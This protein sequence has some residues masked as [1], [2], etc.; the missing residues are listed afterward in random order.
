MSITDKKTKARK[1][2][3]ADDNSVYKI[4]GWLIAALL[5][6]VIIKY[7]I[8]PIH[9]GNSGVL[10]QRFFHGTRLDRFY[11]EGVHIIFP[12]DK[13][14]IYNRR[15][16]TVKEKITALTSTG[17]P[18]EIE[19]AVYFRVSNDYLPHLH[20]NI[21]PD[22]I[23][24]IV[25]PMIISIIRRITGQLTAEDVFS[26]QNDFTNRLNLT[27]NITFTENF[28]ELQ[29]VYLVKISLPEAIIKAIEQKLVEKE[30]IARKIFAVQAERHEKLRR[31]I[32][33]K[34]IAIYNKTVS[35]S[36]SPDILTWQGIE[37]TRQLSQSNNTKTII[38][39]SGKE[40]LPIILNE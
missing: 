11:G 34:G 6:V 3:K 5:I 31:E 10:W 2:R 1:Q 21:G 23:N 27:A 22:Y 36:L 26:F 13:M 7:S 9:A 35:K 25:K 33:S 20:K 18:I 40:G 19:M 8:I 4:L 32:E 28:M 12:W 16:Q 37:A 15:C 17:L 14:Y 29:D 30:R 38:V 24:I 39:G